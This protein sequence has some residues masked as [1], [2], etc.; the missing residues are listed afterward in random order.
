MVRVSLVL[1][2][3]HGPEEA[4]NAVAIA[5]EAL[6]A[7]QA[8]IEIVLVPW[9]RS[10]VALDA[11]DEEG[12]QVLPSAARGWG[13]AVRDGLHAAN[14]DVLCFANPG[15]VAPSAIGEI[16][17]RS[18][19]H[20]E[21]VWRANRRT[22]DS[23]AQKLG[24]LA[25][26]VEVRLAY[27]LA[28]WDVN[29]TPKAFPRGF[30]GLLALTSDD[31]LYDLEFAVVCERERYPVLEIPLRCTGALGPPARGIGASAALRLFAGA[32]RRRHRLGRTLSAT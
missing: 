15:K 27:G 21:V 6:A 28:T 18:V 26:N 1:P 13:A 20:P 7:V 22:R 14:G 4:R 29:G 11:L 3:A 8:D 23:V 9:T 12:L 25:Y 30:N 16:V 24:S 5:R 17:G 19:E 10:A 2:W 31:E 32:A